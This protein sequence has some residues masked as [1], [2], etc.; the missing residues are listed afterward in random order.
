L[1]FLFIGWQAWLSYTGVYQESWMKESFHPNGL[2]GFRLSLESIS[3][4]L[5]ANAV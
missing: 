3:F 5:F 2:M 4:H 1:G